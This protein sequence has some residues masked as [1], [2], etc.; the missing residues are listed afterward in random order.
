MHFCC[1]SSDLQA[2][3][4]PPCKSC[5]YNAPFKK[6]IALWVQKLSNT[7]DII[8][9]WL[10]VQN[11]WVYLEAVFVGG[12]IAKQLPK[13]A[14][15]FQ[16]ID[17]SWVK[18][19]T[20]AHET[21]N[22]V[23]CCVGDETLGQLL[24]HLLEQLELCQKSLSG[25]LEKKRLV[26]PRFFFVSD[27]ALLEILGQASDSHTIQAHLLGV[28]DNVKSVVFH[29]KDYD[30]ILAI[31]SR[32]NETIPLEKPVLAQGNVEFWLGELMNESMSSLH[33]VIR[34]ASIA[35]QSSGFELLEFLN[36]FAAQVG[37]LGIQIIWTR[38]A[39]EALK[40]ARSDK[41]IMAQTN[42]YFLDM[43]NTLIEVTTQDLSKV[44]RIKYETL[45]TIHVHQR[46]IFNDMV[47][48]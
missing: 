34:D 8:E 13:E 46:D 42:A 19:M 37:L 39:E 21:P 38:D 10:T 36:S 1:L 33:A 6:E 16:N 26:F 28:F 17:K 23:Q 15:R 7:S 48:L 35:V 14:K 20:K 11:L 25:Y 12:D 24:P 45:I 22:V 9:N 5:R 40:N 27:P 18:I 44:E 3:L 32:E 43:L 2:K 29:E 47:S 4:S 41:K 30:R 31:S